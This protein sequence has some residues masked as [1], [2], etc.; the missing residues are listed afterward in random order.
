MEAS[1]HARHPTMEQII[2]PTKPRAMTR[3]T[4]T[5]T[6]KPTAPMR[7]A[8]ETTAALLLLLA[9]TTP[10]MPMKHALIVPQTAE[11][12]WTP[13][14]LLPPTPLP[15]RLILETPIPH[16]RETIPLLPETEILLSP[17]FLPHLNP[18]QRLLE[19]N[20]MKWEL[21]H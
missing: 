3:E 17:P 20:G 4:T 18:L 11:Y 15:T 10:A 9:E 1:T 8:P 2:K 5:A 7:A 14:I 12:A 19:L 13:P 21:S 16:S 6:D